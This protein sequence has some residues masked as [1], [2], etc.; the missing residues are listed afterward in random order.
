MLH[1]EEQKLFSTSL[2]KT[3]LDLDLDLIRKEVE[4]YASRYE[5]QYVSNIGGYQS[6][7]FD[8]APLS[9][10]IKENTPKSDK[11]MGDLYIYSW[12]NINGPNCYN[13]IHT[14]NTGAVFLSGVY[15][16][17]VPK[18]ACG[19]ILFHD[20]RGKSIGAAPDLKYF[21]YSNNVMIKPEENMLYYF[22]S[23]LE[24]EVTCNLSNENRISISFNLTRKKQIE[25]NLQY[26]NYS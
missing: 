1:I 4:L 18:D 17:T 9:S 24:H 10:A 23:W 16:V 7:P 25:E 2:W 8:Y 13:T 12:V 20:P 6:G 21:E 11:E 26:L 3:K 22:P 14:H 15:Y 19:A 5:S